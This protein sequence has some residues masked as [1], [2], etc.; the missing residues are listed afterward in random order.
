MKTYYFN[1]SNSK[2]LADKAKRQH[3]SALGVAARERI[4][5][6]SAAGEPIRVE[7]RG[8]HEHTVTF[9]D[10][11]TGEI[12]ALDLYRGKRRDQFTATVDGKPWRTVNATML[13]KL[14]RDKFKPHI[15]D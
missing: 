10:R 3:R 9:H 12:H 2:S 8:R 7:W 4:R 14:V 6:A 15:R 5:M 1:R 13:G 11:M